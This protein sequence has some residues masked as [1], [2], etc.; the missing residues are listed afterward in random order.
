MTPLSAASF[1]TLNLSIV[2]RATFIAML[3]SYFKKPCGILS[4][5]KSFLIFAITK[6]ITSLSA[7]YQA[8]YAF[9]AC[10]GPLFPSCNH[11]GVHISAADW[12]KKCQADQCLT[13]VPKVA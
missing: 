11:R 8:G 13:E 3:P 1:T 10:V 4:D 12:I 6:S 5:T 2:H 9:E 7:L